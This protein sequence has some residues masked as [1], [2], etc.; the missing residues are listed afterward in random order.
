M[1]QFIKDITSLWRICYRN[2]LRFFG[3]HKLGATE[4]LSGNMDLAMAS[5]PFN[6]ELES[7]YI[8]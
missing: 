7:C 3:E 2:N 1:Q 6:E 5:G 4:V 8:D